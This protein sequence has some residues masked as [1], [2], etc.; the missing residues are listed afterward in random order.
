MNYA[1]AI[2]DETHDI[3]AAHLLQH[4]RDEDVCFALYRPSRGESRFS[5]LISEP[6]LPREGERRVHRNVSVAAAYFERAVGTAL[7]EGAG[8]AFLHSHT[9]RSRG[10]QKMSLDDLDTEN[11]YAPRALAMTELPL[12]GLTLAG[13]QFWSA[14]AWEKVDRGTYERRDCESVRVV[15]ERLQMSFHPTLRPAPGFRE[16][17]TRTISAWGEAAQADLARLHVGIVGLGNVGALVAEALVRS[18]VEWLTLIDFD[19]VKTVNLDRLLNATERDAELA[20][21]KVEVASDSLVE[22]ATAAHPRIDTYEWSVVE[23]E[24]FR[25]AL[26]CDVLFSCV[27]RPWARAV[28][29]FAAYAHLIPV[30]DGGIRV[31]TKDGEMRSADWKAHVAIPGRRCLECLEQFNPAHVTLERQGDLDDPTY[32]DSLPDDHGLRSN[33]NVFA[34]GMAAASLE[35]MQLLQMVVAPGGVSD[36]GSQHYNFKTG[37]IDIE[38]RGCN[39]GCPYSEQLVALGEDAFFS[40]LG[41]HP[42]AE[43][44]RAARSSRT[45]ARQADPTGATPTA[46][47]LLVLLRAIKRQVRRRLRRG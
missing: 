15:G 21:S 39:P 38:E 5:A 47:R 7:A 40:P 29:N 1:A 25:A 26:D 31:R 35:L 2:T 22:H 30:V 4:V 17:L 44:E 13:D 3:L 10:W 18:G 34:F 23:Q 45:A 19:T 12:L 43:E 28:L 6:I 24:G 16:S 42:V 20:R 33:E 46:D 11:I 27:D 32:I 36:V 8:L 37:K 14:R 9:R 41:K